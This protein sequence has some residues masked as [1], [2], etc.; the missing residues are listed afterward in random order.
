MNRISLAIGLL[1]LAMVCMGCE[2]E[3]GVK[4]VSPAIGV[5]SGGEP[6]EIQGSGFHTGM[7]ISVYVGS[8]KADNV[9]IRGSDKLTITTPS[10]KEPGPVDIRV[11][12]DSGQEFLIAKGFTYV[13]KSAGSMDIRELGKRKSMR[14]KE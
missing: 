12:T 11:I 2:K 5:M 4:R 9:T 10:A 3:L 14:K 1:V 8:Y 13:E 7:G 6:V